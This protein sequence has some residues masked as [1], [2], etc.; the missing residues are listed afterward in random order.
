MD[1]WQLLRRFVDH[2]SQEAFA[3][4]TTRYLNLVYSVCRRELTDAQTAEDVTQAVF[5]ILARKAPTL[6]RSVILSGWL[7]QT[8][9]FAARNARRREARRK[10]WEERAMEQMPSAEG[11]GDALWD[12]ISPVVNDALAALGAKDREAVLLRFAEGLSFP[13]LGMALGTSEDA[14][15]MRLNR[16]IDR[17]RRFFAKQ[18]VPLSAAVLIGLLADRTTQAAPAACAVAVANLAGGS[19]AAM[20]SPN[21]QSQ[22][23][24]VLKA[25]TISKL[26]LAATVGI[27]TVLAGSLPFVTLAQ[28]RKGA[29]SIVSYKNPAPRIT[30]QTA[31]VRSGATVLEQAARATASIQS[32][33]ADV[34]GDGIIPPA[35][36]APVGRLSLKRPAQV[37]SDS[38]GT[39]GQTSVVNGQSF[40]FYTHWDKKYQQEAGVNLKEDRVGP[41]VFSTF[42]F[43]PQLQGLIFP[44]LTPSVGMQT[45]LM[46]TRHWH[47]GTY[48][49]VQLTH[50]A[51]K[52]NEPNPMS[53][54]LTAYFGVA[55]H[56]L[57]GFTVDATYRG[58]RT[59]EEYALKNLRVNP[60]L[61]PS[62]FDWTPPAGAEPSKPPVAHLR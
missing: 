17:L 6:R 3:T 16:A 49:A 40:W 45:H 38:P 11:E 62:M 32:L 10:A 20:I 35:K 21:I 36:W 41:P 39:Y 34:E 13:E 31:T 55:D 22:L 51:G 57:H 47:G 59:V 14:A 23:Q 42:F 12:Q 15:R 5:L 7:F 50:P 53:G 30:T 58:H 19:S 56:L 48:T 44:G 27:G 18:G 43:N 46:G 60:Q 25:M 54:S 4:L 2:N 61:P 1:D 29:T 8:A 33:S 52:P 37:L 9:R 28:T 26:K 24:G